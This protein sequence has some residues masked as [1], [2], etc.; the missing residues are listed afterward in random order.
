MPYLTLPP[1]FLSLIKMISSSIHFPANDIISFFKVEF[2]Y[3][4]FIPQL[5]EKSSVGGEGTLL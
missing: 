3:K 2:F 1:W 4:T 5:N